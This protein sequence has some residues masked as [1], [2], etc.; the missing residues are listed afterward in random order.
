M[1]TATNNLP[2]AG[3]GQNEKL[4]KA[5]QAAVADRNLAKCANN[6]KWN[7][8]I[9]YFRERE[10]W[11][12]SYR[13][14]SL[15]GP[16]TGWDVEWFAH[17]PFPFATVEWFDIGLWEALPRKGR[18]LPPEFKDHTEEIAGVLKEI[19]FEFEVSGDVARIWGY[20]PKSREDFPPQD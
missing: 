5:V 10:G 9:T 1:T 4:R 14:K 6:T 15:L 17:L 8:L 18:L 12:P 11:C 7:E 2:M 13:S 3:T 19:G 20:A 16:I